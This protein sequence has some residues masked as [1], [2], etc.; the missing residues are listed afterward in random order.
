MKDEYISIKEHTAIVNLVQKQSRWRDAD[1][2]AYNDLMASR[3]NKRLTDAN[4]D[5]VNSVLDRR[6][7][8]DYIDFISVIGGLLFFMFFWVPLF[9]YLWNWSANPT[10]TVSGFTL[11]DTVVSG[12]PPS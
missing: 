6:A 11:N 2:E 8:K 7:R 10:P 12:S 5:A 1:I 4:K 9:N 3:G